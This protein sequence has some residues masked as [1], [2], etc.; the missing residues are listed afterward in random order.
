MCVCVCVCAA[1]SGARG[2]MFDKDNTLTRHLEQ[3]L[4][5]DAYTALQSAVQIFGTTNVF[6]LSN[7]LGAKHDDDDRVDAFEDVMGGGVKVLRHSRWKKPFGSRDALIASS[8]LAVDDVA[9]MVFV[10][11][12]VL[13]DVV[14]ANRMKVRRK[15]SIV[16][17]H[18]WGMRDQNTMDACVVCLLQTMQR[19]SVT[20]MHLCPEM[21]RM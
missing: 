21:R 3:Q 14:F 2:V 17:T 15:Y 5:A 8:K 19:C 7:D 4:A 11:D 1:T 18:R 9:S 12:R 6:V 16:Y 10:G 20:A 13:T